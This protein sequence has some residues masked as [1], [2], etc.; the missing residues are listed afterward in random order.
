MKR[1]VER[2]MFPGAVT[3]IARKARSCIRRR[4]ASST[5][6]RRSR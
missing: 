6:R 3:L 1:E 2:G 4:T 5:P